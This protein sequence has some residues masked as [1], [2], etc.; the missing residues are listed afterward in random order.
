MTE[1]MGDRAY[2]YGARISP[3]VC[4]FIATSADLPGTTPGRFTGSVCIV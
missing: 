1:G 2:G 3:M 4:K